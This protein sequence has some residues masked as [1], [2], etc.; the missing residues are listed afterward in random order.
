MSQEQY[1]SKIMFALAK[2]IATYNGQIFDKL[3]ERTRRELMTLANS[4]LATVRRLD[5]ASRE[6]LE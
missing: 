6:V 3:D 4:L 2:Q 1:A 5:I